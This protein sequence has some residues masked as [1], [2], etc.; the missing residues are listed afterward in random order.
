MPLTS[1]IIRHMA[2]LTDVGIFDVDYKTLEEHLENEQVQQSTL[3]EYLLSGFQIV[4]RQQR[5]MS[6][7][8]TTLKLLLRVGAKW[9]HEASFKD[10]MTAYHIICQSSGDHDELLDLTINLC[11]PAL[12]N[13]RSENGSTALLCAVQNANLNCVKCLIANGANVY[14]EDKFFRTW[15]PIVETIERLNPHSKYPANIMTDIFDLLLDSIDD[16]NMTIGEFRPLP[17]IY[18]I[19]HGNVQCAKK[20]IQK[21]ARFY[22][23]DHKYD[24]AWG[25][26]VGKGNVELLRCMFDIGF[27]KNWTDESGRS[28]LSHL[29][30]SGNVEAI[31]FLLDRDVTVSN[32]I[33]TTNEMPCEDCGKKIQLLGTLRDQRKREPCFIAC[34]MKMLPVVQLLEEYGCEDFK[35]I[36]VLRH[37]VIHRSL[38][39]IKYLLGKYTYPLNQA[40]A[41]IYSKHQTIL[42]ETFHRSRDDMIHLLLDHGADPNE[43]ICVKEC[44]SVTHTAISYGRVEIVA[45]IIRSGLEYRSY[46]D[47]FVTSVLCGNICAAEM[48]LVTGCACGVY[49]LDDDQRINV[50]IKPKLNS[51]MKKWHVHENNVT[52][53]Q[54]QCR[55]A[56]LSHLSPQAEK[57]IGNLPLP[58]ILITYLRIPELDDI[59]E[60]Y[61]KSSKNQ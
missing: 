24:Y 56:I 7:V 1:E 36:H 22:T 20:L 4:Q 50:N 60:L 30:S 52:P 45:R 3:D 31:R 11:G 58:P 49:S 57:K 16:I 2:P 37:A 26:A 28:M 18:A 29:V 47:M 19:Y 40:Y 6:D 59:L 25:I 9:K 41:P 43:K 32:Y 53:L 10:G 17:I 27:D 34:A 46:H 15:N 39:V 48:L 12:V 8:A 55:R 23:T 14:V 38:D 5:D 54:R 21:G 35:C 42:N 13:K 51:L 44:I 33:P 61:R